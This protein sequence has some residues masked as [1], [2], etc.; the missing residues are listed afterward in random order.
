[1]RIAVPL[2]QGRF[3]EHFGGAESFAFYTVDEASRTVGERA[4][5]APPEH[6]RGVFP[7]WLKN[8]GADV[9]LAAVEDVGAAGGVVVAPA[10]RAGGWIE[11]LLAC[12]EHKAARLDSLRVRADRG[13]CLVRLDDLNGIPGCVRHGAFSSVGSDAFRASPQVAHPLWID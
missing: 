9:V 5:G 13:T 3:S 1:M 2:L 4:T 11:A 6:G 12:H 8:Q 10:F 7:M